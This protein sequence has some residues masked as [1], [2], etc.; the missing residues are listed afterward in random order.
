M[1]I[2]KGFKTRIYPTEEQIEYFNK[3][4]GIS[5]YCYNWYLEKMRYNYENGIKQSFY[6]LRKEFNSLR[7]KEGYSLPAS[8]VEIKT[9]FD[10]YF[11]RQKSFTIIKKTK[12]SEKEVDLKPLV[13]KLEIEEQNNKPVFH[14]NVSTGSND[15]IKPELVI[16]SVY[17]KCGFSYC[18]EAIQIHRNEVYTR[19]SD[20][21]LLSLM[22]MG[23]EIK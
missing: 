13:Y 21:S 15:N 9:G 14:I 3:W 20:G 23:E 22:D 10:K 16:A 12:K 4:F 8:F 18:P 2:Y 11:I 17:E 5:R 7:Y 1:E 19:A 6:D